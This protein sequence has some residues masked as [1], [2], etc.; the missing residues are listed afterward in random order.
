MKRQALIFTL[1]CSLCSSAIVLAQGKISREPFLKQS[2]TLAHELGKAY[3]MGLNCNEKVD[4]VSPP[5][6]A[7]LFA[8][9]MSDS[10]VKKAMQHYSNGMEAITG[11]PCDLDEMKSFLVKIQRHL[12]EYVEMAEPFARGAVK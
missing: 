1:L 12:A 6:A 9:Y 5:S 11:G 8:G 10:E 2:N 7:D 3:A 4:S